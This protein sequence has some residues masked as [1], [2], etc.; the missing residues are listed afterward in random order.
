MKNSNTKE[1]AVA[2]VQ[3]HQDKIKVSDQW[4]QWVLLP[5]SEAMQVILFILHNIF[6]TKSIL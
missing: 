1:E 4:E 6:Y 5:F 3:D 2:L